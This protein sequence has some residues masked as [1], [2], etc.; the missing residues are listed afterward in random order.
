[1]NTTK[2]SFDRIAQQEGAIAVFLIEYAMKEIAKTLAVIAKNLAASAS[3]QT[4]KEGV[5]RK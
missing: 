1:M 3:N 2:M 4:Q 5:G